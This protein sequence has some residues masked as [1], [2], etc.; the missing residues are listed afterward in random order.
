MI[1]TNARPIYD[2]E[3]EAIADAALLPICARVE[4]VI[5]TKVRGFL[6]EVGKSAL[7]CKLVSADEYMGEMVKR[8]YC[9]DLIAK[10]MMDIDL[11]HRAIYF[12]LVD[13][14]KGHFKE[15]SDDV[16]NT[17]KQLGYNKILIDDYNRSGR[18]VWSRY[19]FSGKYLDNLRVK[20]LDKG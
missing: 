19:G 1:Y 2:K 16:F 14:P 15:V 17:I 13:F 18:D 7:C 8:N 5:E 12:H 11:H 3:A 10:E 20:Y 9:R 6:F 4:G